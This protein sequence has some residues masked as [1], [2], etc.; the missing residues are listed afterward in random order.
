VIMVAPEGNQY[1][2]KLKDPGVRQR[3]FKKFCEWI[4]KGKSKD[5]FTFKE[6]EFKCT[7][8][9]LLKYFE[10]NPQ[11][12]PTIEREY[13]FAEGYSVWEGVVEDSATGKNKKANTASLQMLMRNKY[14][15]DKRDP[16]SVD[17]TDSTKLNVL[18]EF[19]NSITPS[20]TPAKDKES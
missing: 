17:A 7:Y 12:F 9:T 10:D 18:K 14:G 2:V 6:D 4:A 11:E 1:G 8:K 13:A 20:P 15:W 5:S 19:F 3:A 16:D